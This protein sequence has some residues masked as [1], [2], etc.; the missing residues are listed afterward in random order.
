MKQ[1]A[2]LPDPPPLSCADFAARSGVP[3]ATAARLEQYVRLLATWQRRL[4]LVGRASLADVWR[5]H[6]LD[7]AQ[8][9]PLLPPAARLLVDLGSGAGFPGMVLAIMG[10]PR[11]HLVESN[12][13]KCAFL[14][15]VNRLTGAGARIHQGRIENLAPFDADV[16][17]ARAVAPL[18]RLLA[19]AWPFIGPATQCLFLKGGTIEEEL[20]VAQKN[21]ILKATPIRSLSHRSG[22]VLKVE[23]ISPRHARRHAH[24]HE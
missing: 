11:V 20:T 3:A 21:W 1:G 8:L 2:A 7:S 12:Q 10:G 9:H 24:R 15:E 6:V 5:R 14:G 18:D 16:I 19:R 17:T 13:R 22:V 23:D 4:N